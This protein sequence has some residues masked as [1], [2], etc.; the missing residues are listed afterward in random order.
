MPA[1]AFV[2]VERAVPPDP[3]ELIRRAAGFGI[4]L[5]H[6]SG[7]ESPATYSIAGGGILMVMLIDAPHP[8]VGKMPP[9]IVPPRSCSA[10]RPTTSSC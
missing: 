3:A 9:S 1:L 10:R 8:D 6:E 4:T 2:L 7:T 5:S